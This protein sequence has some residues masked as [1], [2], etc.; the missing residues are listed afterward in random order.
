[1]MDAH[2]MILEWADR[3]EQ[4]FAEGDDHDWRWTDEALR[5][6]GKDVLQEVVTYAYKMEINWDNYSMMTAQVCE[7]HHQW[8]APMFFELGG[9]FYANEEMAYC[10]R[11]GRECD[12]SLLNSLLYRQPA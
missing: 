12:E 6:L 11:C 4:I 10:P 5:D 3:A 8:Y 7:L 9:W 1:M 2:E